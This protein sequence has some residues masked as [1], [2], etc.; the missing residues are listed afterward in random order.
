MSVLELSNQI[1]EAQKRLDNVQSK[2]KSMKENR[3]LFEAGLRTKWD[4]M[5]K[6]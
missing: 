5:Q 1:K 2:L 3:P 4:L 6:P